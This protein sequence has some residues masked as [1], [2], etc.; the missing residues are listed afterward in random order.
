MILSF[1]VGIKNLAFCVMDRQF[2]I[3]SWFCTEIPNPTTQLKNLLCYLDSLEL[4]ENVDTIL[5]EKQPYKNPKMRL[6]ENIL[7]TYFNI[8]NIDNSNDVK[9]LSYN[10]KHKLGELGKQIKGKTNYNQRK[11]LSIQLCNTFLVKYTQED[12]FK[13]Y[14]TKSKKKDDLADS[15]LQALSFLNYNLDIG[16]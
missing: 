16:N 14:F 6:L 1:D 11:K 7:L 4:M 12:V 10:A 5:I 8:R 15:L 3:H 13:Y 9:I 2:N